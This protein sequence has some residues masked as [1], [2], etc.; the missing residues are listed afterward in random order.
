MRRSIQKASMLIMKRM[1]WRKLEKHDSWRKCQYF[2]PFFFGQGEGLLLT[3]S[4][5]LVRTR[6]HLTRGQ[7]CCHLCYAPSARYFL[8]QMRLMLFEPLLKIKRI[9]MVRRIQEHEVESGEDIKESLRINRGVVFFVVDSQQS[10]SL[11]D[12]FLFLGFFN[13]GVLV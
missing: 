8:L 2:L 9:K 12:V 10:A 13:P 1:N 5:W 3:T 11:V 4:L 6:V 7:G